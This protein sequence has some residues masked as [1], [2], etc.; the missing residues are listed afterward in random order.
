[1]V[2]IVKSAISKAENSARVTGADTERHGR[3]LTGDAAAVG[4]VEPVWTA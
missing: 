3:P 4:A 1:M 2:A